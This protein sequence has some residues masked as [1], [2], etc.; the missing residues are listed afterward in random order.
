MAELQN[1]LS[2]LNSCISKKNGSTFAKQIA[3]PLYHASYS[4]PTSV[5]Q[6]SDKIKRVDLVSICE[7][8]VSDCNLQ[9]IIANRLLALISL[10]EDNLESGKKHEFSLQ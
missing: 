4:V 6:F 7:N 5:K 3:L 8:K 1:Y 2:H 9:G 10:A